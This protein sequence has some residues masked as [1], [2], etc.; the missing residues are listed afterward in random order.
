MGK[1]NLVMPTC[2]NGFVGI[3]SHLAQLTGNQVQLGIYLL[4]GDMDHD[5]MG[6]VSVKCDYIVTGTKGRDFLSQYMD[7][8]DDIDNNQYIGWV[9][10]PYYANL[11]SQEANDL[12]SKN[13]TAYQSITGSQFTGSKSV[14]SLTQR[15]SSAD[16]INAKFHIDALIDADGIVRANLNI[17]DNV[18]CNT[19]SSVNGFIDALMGS[20][21]LGKYFN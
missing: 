6:T 19:F 16:A 11:T 10:T 14:N 4:D 12:V 3:G 5:G 21:W 13:L 1:F 8:Y 7:D 2:V 20:S 15:I 17:C 9:Q 18:I